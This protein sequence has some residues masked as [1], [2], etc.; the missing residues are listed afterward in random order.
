MNRKTFIKR[1]LQVSAIGALP[2]LYSWQIEPF[3]VEFVQRNLPI[4]NLPGHLIGK[5]LMQ[6]SDMQCRKPF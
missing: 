3:W 2:V 4:K 5:R 6:I 1:L